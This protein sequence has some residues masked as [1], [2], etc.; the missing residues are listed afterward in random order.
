MAKQTRAKRKTQ[1]KTKA[2]KPAP[3]KPRQQPAE[4]VTKEPEERKLSASWTIA[5]T[6]LRTLK[7]NRQ[8]FG[9]ILLVYAILDLLLVH[10]VAAFNVGAIKNTLGAALTQGSGEVVGGVTI[11]SSLL[12][13]LTTG[14]GSG[15]SGTFQF[16][17]VLIMSLVI[18]YALRHSTSTKP[19]EHK[20]SVKEMFYRSTGQLIPFLL[21]LLLLAVQLLPFLLGFQLYSI[22]AVSGI[23][24]TNFEILILFLIMIGLGL[25]SL[26]WVTR[27]LVALYIVTLPGVQPLEAYRSA[28][29]LVSGRRLAIIRKM[30][31]LPVAMF[32]AAAIIMV[33]VILIWAP[34]AQWLFFG[35]ALAGLI[36]VHA[37]FYSMY[38]EL[39]GE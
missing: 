11:Y 33:P 21:V 4:Q 23:L 5:R 38:R 22:I 3:D 32:I 28:K 25:L 20:T 9:S 12:S 24:T 29:T 8:L 31:F 6:A 30:L 10:S 14:D 13:S 15:S 1:A 34:L 26:Y 36:V 2:S 27:S 7:N 17:V 18:I 16:F 37:Y 35:L 19:A 39:L